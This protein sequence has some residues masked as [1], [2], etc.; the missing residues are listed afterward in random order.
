M[1]DLAPVEG[2]DFFFVDAA[3]QSACNRAPG[4]ACKKD[5]PCRR[6]SRVVQVANRKDPRATRSALTSDAAAR[7]GGACLPTWAT[8]GGG[9]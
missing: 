6:W 9:G 7:A 8:R 5:P 1:P 2:G 4:S 3:C